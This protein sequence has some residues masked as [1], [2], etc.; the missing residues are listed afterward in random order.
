MQNSRHVKLGLILSAYAEDDVRALNAEG[1]EVPAYDVH[2]RGFDI[3]VETRYRGF[4]ADFEWARETYEADNP[5]LT[6]SRWNREGWRVQA[7]YFIKPKRYQLMARYAEIQRLTDPTVAGALD[8]GLNTASIWNPE[9]AQFEEALERKIR[10]VTV[11]FNVYLSRSHGHKAFVDVSRL[12]REFAEV[13]EPGFFTPA[14]Q[15]DGRVRAMLQL[16]F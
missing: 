8:S 2:D 1:D 5:A 10:E 6:V 11:G 7:G 4:S 15:E 3:A 12:I 14:N 16:L 13:D 9:A